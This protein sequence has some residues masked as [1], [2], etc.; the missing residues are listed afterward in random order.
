VHG[1]AAGLHAGSAHVVQQAAPQLCLPALLLLQRF[2][3]AARTAQLVTAFRPVAQP[4]GAVDLVLVEQVGDA[5]GQLEAPTL[6]MVLGEKPLQ[7][8]ERRLGQQTGQQA[9]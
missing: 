6:V 7:R 8:G 1:G 2:R 4:V 3:I 5:L 9:H